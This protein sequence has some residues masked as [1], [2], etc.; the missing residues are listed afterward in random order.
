VRTIR[1]TVEYDGTDFAGWQE[2][3]D[4]PTVQGALRAAVESLVR[5]PT[6]VRGASRTDAG[7][8][9]RGQVAAFDV[10]GDQIPLVGF[11]RGLNTYL[12][13]TVVVRDVAEAPPGWD[14]RRTSR[15]K[16]YAYRY[17][18]GPTRSALERDRTWHV[19][20]TLDR[21]AMTN[22]SRALLGTH[23]F[24][25]FR[26][27]GCVAKHAVRTL[28]EIRLEPGPDHRLDLWV[29]GNAFVR[30]MVRI[31]AGHLAEV[32][33]GRLPPESVAEALS[34]RDRSRAGITAPARGLTLEEVVYDERLPPR[35]TDDADLDGPPPG[36]PGRASD[37]TP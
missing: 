24:E 4:L 37:G 29:V 27:S 19:R 26:A 13:R 34:A 23:D 35:P 12:P 16:V 22:A 25:A 2:Q 3:G 5:T 11:L 1:L 36:A 33:L 9:A 17:W 6:R 32:G 31:I 7:V 20:G 21:D 14:P 15:G 10:D 30:N 8:H 18:E 28:Y